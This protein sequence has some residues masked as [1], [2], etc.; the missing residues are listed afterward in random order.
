MVLFRVLLHF[1]MVSIGFG[2]GIYI[3]SITISW[4][5]AFVLLLFAATYAP[6]DSR[7]SWTGALLWVEAWVQSAMTA[8][9]VMQ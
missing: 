9:V 3:Q 2:L 4:L 1:E 6:K 5:T 8:I 7:I